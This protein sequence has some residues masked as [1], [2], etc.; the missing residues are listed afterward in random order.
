M[1]STD[2]RRDLLLEVG[3]CL[4]GEEW[5]RPL[6]RAVARFRIVGEGPLDPRL[7]RRWVAGDLS[8]PPW[9]IPILLAMVREQAEA[10]AKLVVALEQEAAPLTPDPPSR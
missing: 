10:T 4:F 8:V 6:S 9:M 5:Q 3:T 7:I 1:S 2:R